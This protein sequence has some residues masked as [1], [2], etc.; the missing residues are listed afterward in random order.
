M[1]PQVAVTLAFFCGALSTLGATLPG[2]GRCAALPPPR[3]R[4]QLARAPVRG[5][6]LGIDHGHHCRWPGRRGAHQRSPSG[7]IVLQPLRNTNGSVAGG[8]E[9]RD[10]AASASPDAD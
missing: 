9:V 7:P 1:S 10:T 5:L 4:V 3:T 2:V 8:P 6:G